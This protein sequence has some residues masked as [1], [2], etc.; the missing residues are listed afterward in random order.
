[1]S[2]DFKE[3]EMYA[4]TTKEYKALKAAR[5]QVEQIM[6]EKK[7]LVTM[8]QVCRYTFKLDL[9]EPAKRQPYLPASFD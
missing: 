1:M 3:R 8:E 2:R 4:A 5:K 9:D 7:K 6:A